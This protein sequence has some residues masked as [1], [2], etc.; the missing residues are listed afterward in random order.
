MKAVTLVLVALSRPTAGLGGYEKVVDVGPSSR[1]HRLAAW[2][3]ASLQRDV[4]GAQNSLTCG[5]L[6]GTQL[7]H[8]NKASTQVVSGMNYA[9]DVETERGDRLSLGLY[10]QRWSSTL[11]LTS[12]SLTSATGDDFG[13]LL[14]EELAL[15]FAAFEA[16][17]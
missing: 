7:G 14:A 8:V 3:L 4:C 10:E 1:V 11:S 5:R 16:S 9:I 6:V 2:A 17:L 12:A 13:S 15:D